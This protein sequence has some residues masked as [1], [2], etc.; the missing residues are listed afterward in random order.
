MT[1]LTLYQLG[2]QSDDMLLDISQVVPR[3]HFVPVDSAADRFGAKTIS[4]LVVDH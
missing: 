1:N 2:I 4:Q 3:R